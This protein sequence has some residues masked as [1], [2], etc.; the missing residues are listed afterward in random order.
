MAGLERPGAGILLAAAR[1]MVGTDFAVGWAIDLGGGMATHAED[2]R[3]LARHLDMVDPDPARSRRAFESGAY[4]DCETDDLIAHLEA[5]PDHYD[6][7]LATGLLREAADPAAVFSAVKIALA[8]AGVFIALAPA[9]SQD[10]APHDAEAWRRM[11]QAE[12]LIVLAVEP[13][14]LPDG[15]AGFCLAAES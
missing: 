7:I 15:S 8:L 12:G 3:R 1:Q 6:L 5:R 10:G 14:T 13:V 11:A 2:L 9:V 4:D